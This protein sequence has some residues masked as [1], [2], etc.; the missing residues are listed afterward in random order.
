MEKFEGGTAVVT[1][2]ASGLGLAFAHRFAEAG[3]NVVLADIEAEPL[4]MAEA[5]VAAKGVKVM[6]VRTDVA[7]PEEIEALATK[8]YERFG[9]VNILCNN[10]GIGG[11]PGNVWELSQKDWEWVIDVDLWSVINGVRSFVPRMIASGEEGHVINT[12]SVAGLVSGAVGGP[13]TVAKF[14]V[15]ALSEQ[16]YFE[17]GRAGHK[18]GVSVLCPGFV[19]TNIY[20]SGRNRQAAYGESD[21]TPTPEGEQRRA[22]LN[23]MRGQ[24]MQPGEI[25]EL[26][27]EA[28]RT[29]NLYIVP[30]GS[31]A[32][33]SAVRTRLENVVERKNPEMQV[34]IA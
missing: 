2:G 16:L 17:L 23:A 26:V 7:N 8:T 29:R 11:S 9:K 33:E 12:A 1:G 31:E 27:F 32:L 19:N 25:A 3:M 14:G 21:V 5:S 13:Y 28:V 22:M 4:A 24:M 34:S 20:D 15:V 10:A 6:P 30:T 18:V